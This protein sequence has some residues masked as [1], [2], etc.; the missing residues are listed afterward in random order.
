ML[1]LVESRLKKVV[2]YLVK[3]ERLFDLVRHY[4]LFDEAIIIRE[5]PV[6]LTA[7]LMRDWADDTWREVLNIG[8]SFKDY[9][10]YL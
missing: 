9:D 3:S 6:Y 4:Q 1:L 10:S 7:F 2:Q 5:V 8:L